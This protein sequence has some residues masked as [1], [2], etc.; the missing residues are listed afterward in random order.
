MA[1][2]PKTFIKT[3]EFI[4]VGDYIRSANHRFFAI[5]QGDGNF[6]V[7]RSDIPGASYSAYLWGT[8][9]TADGGKF[10][11]VMQGDGNLCVYRGTG[12]GDQHGL[13]WDSHRTAAGGEFFAVLQDDGNFCVYAGLNPDDQR[14]LVWDSHVFDPSGPKD[15][16][17]EN[18]EIN[19][20]IR[21]AVIAGTKQ[22][23]E[24]GA[25]ISGLVGVL[26]PE[27]GKDTWEQIKGQMEALINKKLADFK[28]QEVKDFLT[29]LKNV[30]NDYTQALRDTSNSSASYITEKYNVAFGH[31]EAASP[32]FMSKDYEALL[33]PLLAQMANLH[34]ALLRDGVNYGAGWGWTCRT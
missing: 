17:G 25:L 9:N 12:P 3:N 13:L 22:I 23:P 29:G 5:M 19:K 24:A 16:S 28:Y 30:I 32:H 21:M 31:F 34:L 6:C 7:Y 1:L 2:L 11:L 27:S 10:F 33:L 20:A 15:I 18:P 14:Q 26:W 8:A 4:R